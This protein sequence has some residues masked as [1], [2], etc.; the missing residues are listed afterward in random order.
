[1]SA[2]IQ[3]RTMGGAIA[4]AIATAAMNTHIKSQLAGFLSPDQIGAILETTQAFATLP[5]ALAESAKIVFASGY[6]LQIRIMIGFSAAQI[7]V[8]LAM[9]QRKNIVV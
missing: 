6:S 1:M 8:A 5:P 7:P 9:W 2:M 4:L 3:F